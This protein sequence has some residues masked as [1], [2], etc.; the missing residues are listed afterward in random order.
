MNLLKKEKTNYHRVQK[1]QTLHQ[2]ATFFCVAERLLV[3]ENHLK[4]E[5][6]PGQ[7]LKIPEESGDIYY[8]KE[9]DTK[10]LLCGSEENYL[11]KNGTNILYI[12]M[13][14]IL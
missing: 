13:R 6:V 4:S 5:P 8:V 9:G 10:R 7:I 14:V 3:K 2:I 12:G 11:K 1:G